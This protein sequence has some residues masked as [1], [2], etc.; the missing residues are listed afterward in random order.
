M[1]K[2]K[3][4]DECEREFDEIR[5]ELET[6]KMKYR[7]SMEESKG[8]TREIERIDDYYEES[9]FKLEKIAEDITECQAKQRS[10]A[11]REVV[12]RENISKYYEKLRDAK[13]TVDDAQQDRNLF[14]TEIRENE[15]KL[16]NLREELNTLKEKISLTR[17]EQSKIEVRMENLIEHVRERS[18]QNLLKI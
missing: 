1:Q 4:L 3:E 6:V 9:R 8:L 16:E 15:K 17:M 14:H 18:N 12:L 10:F 13:E 5:E 2:K 7:V 11:E